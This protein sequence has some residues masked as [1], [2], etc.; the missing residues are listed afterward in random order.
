MKV[1]KS[2]VINQNL[3]LKPK[4]KLESLFNSPLFSSYIKSNETFNSWHSILSLFHFQ[5]EYYFC[6]L[7]FLCYLFHRPLMW[8]EGEHCASMLGNKGSPQ[9]LMWVWE[10][11]DCSSDSRFT[12]CQMEN[13]KIASSV[14]FCC[15]KRFGT[16]LCKSECIVAEKE[17]L[18]G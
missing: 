6:I 3:N 18:H 8:R 16:I 1:L 17:Y 15:A 5:D 13:R 7:F 9:E 11:K 2:N 10:G 14:N 4:I 12:N